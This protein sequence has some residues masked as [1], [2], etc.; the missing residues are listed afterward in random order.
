MREDNENKNINEVS[1]Q[2]EIIPPQLLND[3]KREVL[4]VKPSQ[5]EIC[6]VTYST[7]IPLTLNN[8]ESKKSQIDNEENK[9]VCRICYETETENDKLINPCNCTGSCKYLHQSCIK[10][11][12]VEIQKINIIGAQFPKCE[13][14]SSN[15][16]LRFYFELKESKIKKWNAYKKMLMIWG[17]VFSILVGLNFGIEFFLFGVGYKDRIWKITIPLALIS[18]LILFVIIKLQKKRLVKMSCIWLLT[19]WEVMEKESVDK[20]TLKLE[21]FNPEKH[22]FLNYIDNDQWYWYLIKDK[23]QIVIKKYY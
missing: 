11:W 14:C 8:E 12:L 13:V 17:T 9:N 23:S 10:R 7:T 1:N 21:N 6:P 22:T 15:I 4:E 19:S 2:N 5:K 16:F 18:L 20:F 3:D